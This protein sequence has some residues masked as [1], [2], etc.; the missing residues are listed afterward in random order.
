M[1]GELVF[2]SDV[3]DGGA[4]V[5]NTVVAD[6]VLIVGLAAVD[7]VIVR[8]VS[9]YDDVGVALPSVAGC[10]VAEGDTVVVVI[11]LELLTT[12]SM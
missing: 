4:A 8:G 1:T 10:V 7:A 6:P 3:V 9:A 5:E 12:A 11:A 2:L